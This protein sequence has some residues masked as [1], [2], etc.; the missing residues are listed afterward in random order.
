MSAS[1]IRMWR[2]CWLSGDGPA[3]VKAVSWLY[4]L[5]RPVF[6]QFMCTLAQ[7]GQAMIKSVGEGPDKSVLEVKDIVELAAG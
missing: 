1:L 3:M 6:P 5:L 7:V 4:P 2:K